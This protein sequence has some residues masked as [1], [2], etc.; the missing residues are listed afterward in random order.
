MP[1]RT[2][3]LKGNDKGPA[4]NRGPGLF[5]SSSEYFRR[6]HRA[7]HKPENIQES[8]TTSDIRLPSFEIPEPLPDFQV[9]YLLRQQINLT[10]DIP[11]LPNELNKLSQV[12]AL[13]GH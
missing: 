1:A 5:V 13:V 10:P 7:E 4:L 9:L 3:R 11:D 12:P 2:D 8:Q 6:N